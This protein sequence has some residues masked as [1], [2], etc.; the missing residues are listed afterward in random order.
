MKYSEGRHSGT[1]SRQY[2]S[3]P[4][5]GQPT[6]YPPILPPHLSTACA[7]GLVMCMYVFPLRYWRILPPP[8]PPRPTSSTRWR[9]LHIEHKFVVLESVLLDEDFGSNIP[10]AG[11]HFLLFKLYISIDWSSRGYTVS[12]PRLKQSSIQ[13]SIAILWHVC[14]GWHFLSARTTQMLVVTT[15]I[16]RFLIW[17]S[18]LLHSG[19]QW[20]TRT[21]SGWLNHE[22][23]NLIFLTI[24]QKTSVQFILDNC[25]FVPHYMARPNYILRKKK[26]YSKGR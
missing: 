24:R 7:T 26:T 9:I 10:H 1:I 6:I 5:H 4:P 2:H 16:W 8:P 13:C 11:L 20:G 23:F 21:G 22:Q 17:S 19:A 12:L 25:C 14:P 15:W 3:Y 18:L